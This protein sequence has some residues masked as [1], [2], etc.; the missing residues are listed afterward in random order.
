MSA[1]ASYGARQ[2]GIRV[3]LC[4]PDP[5]VRA[6]LR[7]AIENDPLLILAGE[8]QNWADCEA[9]LD[10][11]VPELLIARAELIPVDW[12]SRSCDR[13]QPVV[14]A[15]RTTL[16]FPAE[17][18][19]IIR[20]PADLHTIKTALDHAV[21]EIYDRKAKQL[22]YLVDRYVSGS[23]STSPYKAFIQ[24]ETDGYAIDLQTD[25]IEAV[26]AARKHVIIHSRNGN[27][28][29]RE[30][31]RQI[32]ARLDPHLFIRIHRSVIINIRQIDRSVPLDEKS[33]Y[34]VLNDGSRYPIGPNYR[35]TA[36]K[37]LDS[38]EI[39]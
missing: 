29:L 27:F 7:V 36:A 4:E 38:G 10:E 13:F 25:S 21:R 17:E 14:I 31:I 23:Q 34:V 15:L 35:S 3:T 6:Q 2:N 12:S 19:N 22:L 24:V 26:V 5:G 18:C 1:Y 16:S 20:I 37:A 32:A 33:S 28:T 30:P 39:G 8:S 11:T 9:C